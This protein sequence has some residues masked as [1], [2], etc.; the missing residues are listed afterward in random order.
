MLVK[1]HLVLLRK[2]IKA[3]MKIIP[4]DRGRMSYN[5][6]DVLFLHKQDGTYTSILKTQ[7]NV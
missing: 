5:V 2:V 4:Q 7:G 3:L 6:V 1:Y